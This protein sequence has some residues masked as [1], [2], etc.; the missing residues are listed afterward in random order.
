MA[1][2]KVCLYFFFGTNGLGRVI[3]IHLY[4]TLDVS[5]IGF[6]DL[7]GGIRPPPVNG[8]KKPG[9]FRVKEGKPREIRREH[10]QFSSYFVDKYVIR[11]MMR[12][13]I[14]IPHPTLL[15]MSK[16]KELRP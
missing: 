5:S 12:Q 2:Y 6:R 9:S 1:S 14:E 7:G 4:H 16:A 11:V 8:S 13:V 15:T 3:A 10:R